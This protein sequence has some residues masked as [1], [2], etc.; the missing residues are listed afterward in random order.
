[1]T[2][3]ALLAVALSSDPALVRLG[4]DTRAVLT[5]TA[6]AEPALSASVGRVEAPRRL[7]EDS[8]EAD[9][10]P[11][12][13]QLPQ[14]AII[15]AV[16]GDDVAWIAIPLWAEGDAVVKTR[17]GGRISVRIGAEL[18]GP[19]IADARGDAVV[20]VVVPPG[21]REAYQ[22][23]RTIPLNVPA[24]RSIHVALG[25]AA[26]TADQAQ[27][28]SV[29]VVAV[30]PQ[31]A[32]RR[33]AAIRLRASRG[34]LSAVR[35]RGPGVYEA[36]LS[37]APSRA[38][39]VRVTAALDDARAF[40]AEAAVA[41][42]GGPAESVSISADRARIRAEEPEAR[43]H[44]SGRDSAGNAPSEE[45]LFESTAGQVRAT[46]TAPG[47]W[48]LTLS[49]ASS[50]SG[51]ETVEVRAS[52]SKTSASHQLPLL[53]GPLETA[54]F[55]SGEA[56]VIADG[57]SPLRLRIQLR[58]QYGNTVSDVHP[59]LSAGSGQAQLEES[60]GALY[61]SYL[62]PLL[63]ERSDTILSLHAGSAIARSR[64]TLLANVQ[65]TALSAKLGAVSNFAGFSAPL[66]GLEA[67]LR[68]DRFGPELAVSLEADYGHRGYSEM[69]R[70][71][72]S[73]LMAQ[74]SVDLALL[75]L[76]AAWRRPFG[77]ANALWIAAGPSAAAY[78]TRV[79]LGDGASRRGFAVAPGLQGS[80][81]AERRM[82]IVVPFI[83]LRAG[84][85]TSSGLP[86]LEGPLRT[87]TFLGGVRLETR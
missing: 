7:A 41:L 69:Q 67:A 51:R 39:E 50:F 42:T 16:A 54:A 53:P 23:K 70:L 26:L 19:V 77:D 79:K 76:S 34:D 43:L 4:R 29:Y 3:A 36:W 60:E 55:E 11:P 10:I 56:T 37:L 83:E 32:P 66:V 38:G 57:A 8:W 87:L 27:T 78:W 30:T 20:P 65:R 2:A 62:P 25:R 71:G 74:S 1:M 45:L 61:A 14:V 84:W 44:V 35:Q 85:I 9:Y 22:G 33:G 5:V 46:R 59:E 72:T 12:E 18:F 15:T 49:L 24:S 82:R 58:D 64:L 17:P 40:L 80:V 13:D 52:G 63:R 31:G 86:I 6:G 68:T 73:N 75:H 28:I 48:D 81:G 47:E 21:V